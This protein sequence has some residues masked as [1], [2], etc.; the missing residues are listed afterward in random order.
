MKNVKLEKLKAEIIPLMARINE[1]QMTGIGGNYHQC[2]DAL[3]ALYERLMN[4]DLQ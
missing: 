3:T 1:L 2:L 4:A